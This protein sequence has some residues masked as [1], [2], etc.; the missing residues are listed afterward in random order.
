MSMAMLIICLVSGGS[1]FMS[2]L[3]NRRKPTKMGQRITY[4]LAVISFLSAVASGAL[5]YWA[6]SETEDRLQLVHDQ[7]FEAGVQANR[8]QGQIAEIRTPRSLEPEIKRMLVVRLKPY[9]GQKYDMKVFG[10]EDSLELAQAIEAV[11]KKAGWVYTNVYPKHATRRYA[12]TRDDGVWLISGMEETKETS[13]AR[14]ALHRALNEVGLYDDSTALTPKYCVEST[15]PIQK[16]TKVTRIPCSELPIRSI[17]V[18]FTIRDDVIPE[19][20]LV[21]HVGKERL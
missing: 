16:G 12:E 11:F 6:S 18:V 3:F 7:A 5:G 9:A 19:D 21:L 10:N 15:G 4:V 14:M 13:E 8:A 1:S 2:F 20:A 17:E